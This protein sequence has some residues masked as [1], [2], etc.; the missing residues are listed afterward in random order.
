MF[1]H[2]WETIENYF[3]MELLLKQILSQNVV[4]AQFPLISSLKHLLLFE[5]DW[6]NETCESP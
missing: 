2:L 1:L 3:E 5:C 6:N 4:E